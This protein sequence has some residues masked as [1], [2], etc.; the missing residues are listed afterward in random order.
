VIAIAKIIIGIATISMS[1]LKAF[2]R[3][4]VPNKYLKDRRITT[5]KANEI[6]S[7]NNVHVN[8]NEVGIILDFLYFTATF[9][10]QSE[11]KIADKSLS[12]TRTPKSFRK[13]I[14]C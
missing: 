10:K 6:L 14:V 5:K 1:R 7:Q 13:A 2:P 8:E 11:S 12:G 9:S 3:I 4:L